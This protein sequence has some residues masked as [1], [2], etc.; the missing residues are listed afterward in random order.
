MKRKLISSGSSFEEKVGYS[1]AVVQGNWLFMAGTT[2]YNYTTMTISDDIVEQTIQTLKNIDKTLKEAGFERKDIVKVLYIVPK[3]AEF[4]QCWPT[5]KEYFGEI[6]PA[7][8]MI[9]ANLFDEK[10][11]IEIEVT[12]LK[13]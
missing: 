12:G 6:R 9:S 3:A 2:G 13:E 1:R 8:T 5:L 7:S 4:E 10:M 11:K